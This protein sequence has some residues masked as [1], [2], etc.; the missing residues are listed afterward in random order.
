MLVVTDGLRL[1]LTGV[2]IG[3]FLGVAL[4]RWLKSLLFGVSSV[5]ALT[6]ACAILV[7]VVASIAATII[8][9]R[10]ASRVDVATMMREN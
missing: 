5:D 2:L 7:V 9:A 1:T 6:L 3:T 10:R 8:P 4:G